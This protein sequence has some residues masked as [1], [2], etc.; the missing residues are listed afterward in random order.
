MSDFSA[1][2]IDD[3]DVNYLIQINNRI[4]EAFGGI[5]GVRD[6]GTLEHLIY[7]HLN[8]E[9]KIY[10]NAAIALHTILTRHPF[11]DG[12]KRTGFTLALL[13][14]RMENIEIK[15][16]KD[17]IENFLLKVANYEC[18]CRNVEI[19]LKKHSQEM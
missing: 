19:W 15:A 13:I 18:S 1:G 11:F 10:R 3:F 12:N 16:C 2:S 7:F 6:I 17:D 5:K 14:L 9:D 4:V 8:Q